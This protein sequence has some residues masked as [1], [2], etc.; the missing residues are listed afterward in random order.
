MKYKKNQFVMLP[1]MVM[2]SMAA[3]TSAPETEIQ[4][5]TQIEYI[6][7]NVPVFPV[8]PVPDNVTYDRKTDQVSMPL[9]YWQKVAEYKIDIDAIEEY[10]DRLKETVPKED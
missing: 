6:I 5:E 2:L 7:P 1:I 10:L 8:F 3:C 9:W 4:I